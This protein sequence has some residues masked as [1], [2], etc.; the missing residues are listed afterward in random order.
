[1]IGAGAGREE[2]FRALLRQLGAPGALDV[3]V[4]EDIHW[5]DDATLDMLRFLSRRLEH[6][7]A[8]L[9]VTYR[10]DDLAPDA[11]LRVALGDFGSQRLTRRLSL[12]PLSHQA[13][14][15]LAA[16]TGLA[17]ADLHRLTGGNP[18]FL[19][20]VLRTGRMTG[21]VPASARDVV[22]AR[23][24]QLSVEAREVLD[25]AALTGSRVEVRLLE[26][27]TG[28]PASAVDELLTGGLLVE[29]EAGAQFRH[30]I[31]RLAVAQAVPA[32]RA[33]RIHRL[34]LSALRSVDCED[35]ARL[36]FHAEEA[37]D[38]ASALGYAF[39]AARRAARLGSHR[40]AAAQYG[41]ALRCAADADA[42]T[43]A[44]LHEGLADEVAL[45]DRWQEAEGA[46]E[47]A[48]A[49]WREAGDRLREGD[50]LRRLARIRWV[51][52]RGS[53]ALVAV[54]AAV[55]TLEPLGDSTELAWAYAA[56]AFQRMVRGEYEAAIDLALRA[57]ALATRFGATDAL[58]DA[59]DAH[60]ASA[61]QLGQE[62]TGLMHRALDIA[63]AGN[64]QN[65]AARIY[66]NLGAIHACGR[67]FAA[68]EAWLEEGLKYCAE[69]DITTY[70][71]FM[72]GE[73]SSILERTG[74][75][76]EAI[77]M[78]EK[79]VAEAAPLQSN[80]L[81]A[82]IR[83][84]LLRARRGAPGAWDC[85]DEA[86]EISTESHES[87]V[88]LMAQ[89]ARAEAYW[90]EGRMPQAVREAELAADLCLLSDAWHRGEVAAWLARTGS[91]RPA[92]KNVAPPYQALLDGE[93]A[94]SAALWTE[95]GCPYEAAMALAFA[96]S[97]PN[98]TALRDA[99]ETFI[100]LDAG[101]AARI[102]RQRLRALGARSIPGGPNAATRSHPLGLT[103]REQEVLD[104]L[105]IGSTNL[106][107]AEKL[108]ISKKTVDHHVSAILRKL[109]VPNRAA[110]VDH[111]SM[112]DMAELGRLRA[113]RPAE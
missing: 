22:L 6:T 45:L 54:R 40:E 92:P 112:R 35:E 108:F 8:L 44:G 25:V 21:A 53:D 82:L 11:P 88:M 100:A 64:H 14:G 97:A 19:T 75:W 65:Q 74:R 31:A 23:A 111:A 105:R 63:L 94:R 26:A 37:G 61:S 76:D 98:E 109:G 73:R 67:E 55:A 47:R 89:L 87:L 46:A 106:M 20:E 36:A 79:L 34:V 68:A 58:S 42:A 39:A 49:L 83:L 12:A 113:P 60:A 72:R 70:A 84:G 43:V 17:P 51:L 16:G 29:H 7:S 80:R 50:A 56:F 15:A 9:I 110:A 4:V 27:V 91:T 18:F 104:L 59:L 62:W 13:V 101:P 24:A 5:A 93:P 95:L 107:I 2:L 66:T 38:A 32:H 103:Q 41:R 102:A 71:S 99:L 28:H 52:C 1:L 77:A 85:L 3:L 69:H 86:A 10:D 90:L 48:L 78:S 30:E 96:P 81:R 33:Q 57:Q